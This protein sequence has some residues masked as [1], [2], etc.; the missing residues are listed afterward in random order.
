[1]RVVLLVCL[2]ACWTGP[3]AADEPA[4]PAAATTTAS[5][6]LALE[7]TLER[8]PCMGMCPTYTVTIHGDGLVT[9]NGIANVEA[10]GQRTGHVTRKQLGELDRTLAAIRF[11]DLDNQGN[12]PSPRTFKFSMCTDTSHAIVTVKRGA[13]LHR[14]DDPQCGDELPVEQLE[15]LI[16]RLANTRRWI[17]DQ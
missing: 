11:F 15:L 10:T 5:K 16:D 4:H 8:S 6:P 13:K 17:G 12:L 9:W 2:A 14:V 1:M 3:V 7:V